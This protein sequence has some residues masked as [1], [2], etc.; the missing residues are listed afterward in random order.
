[1]NPIPYIELNFDESAEAL[2]SF[3]RYQVYRREEGETDWVKL[4]RIND[5]GLTTYQD[6]TAQSGVTYEYDV[7]VVAAADNGEEVESAHTDGVTG[8]LVIRSAFIHPIGFPEEY[9]EIRGQAAAVAPIQDAQPVQVWGRAA[10]TVHIGSALSEVIRITAT[11]GWED[12]QDAWLALRA[13]LDRQAAG[14]MLCLRTYRGRWFG[15]LRSIPRA[16]ETLLWSV[17]LEFVELHY[18]EAVS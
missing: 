13:L 15:Y 16:D 14:A 12:E 11:R 6:F 8:T 3:L 2:A 5:S 7:T 10:P 18:E 17:D 9:T 4:A 1:M